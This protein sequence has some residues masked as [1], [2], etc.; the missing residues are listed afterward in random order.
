MAGVRAHS[1]AN[2]KRRALT[3]ADHESAFC[4]DADYSLDKEANDG[5]RELVAWAPEEDD[6]LDNDNWATVSQVHKRASGSR[7]ISPL[8]ISGEFPPDEMFAVNEENFGVVSTF[9]AS[10]EQY[11]K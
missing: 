9:S 5:D 1:V 3:R 10:M 2:S 11:T 4:T 6:A 7:M 8:Q